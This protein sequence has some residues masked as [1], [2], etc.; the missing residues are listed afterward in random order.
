ME[1]QIKRF[2]DIDERWYDVDEWVKVEDIL[3]KDILVQ[4]V[5]ELTGEYGK[6]CLVKFTTELETID[7]KGNPRPIVYAFSTGSS[8]LMK[9]IMGAK[10]KGLLPLVGR[11]KK[12]K[13]Y[14]DIV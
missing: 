7:E 12:V 8:V 14:Y 1:K 4:D 2:G 6:Y 3:E 11:I 10:E 9:K 13:R 5:K